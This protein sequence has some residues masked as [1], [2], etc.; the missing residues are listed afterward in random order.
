MAQCSL[1][2]IVE[3][4]QLRE[5]ERSGRSSGE[6]KNRREAPRRHL[7]NEDYRACRYDIGER[8]HAPQQRVAPRQP[9]TGKAGSGGRRSGACGC[10]EIR[11][12]SPF[13]LPRDMVRRR[14]VHGGNSFLS[15]RP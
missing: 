9:L 6:D 7:Q 4:D 12:V 5:D 3:A 1:I 2:S 10:L 14:H 13:S 15:R 8:K 11:H